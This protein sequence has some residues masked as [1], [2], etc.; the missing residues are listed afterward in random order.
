MQPLNA[1]WRID[2]AGNGND[3]RPGVDPALRQRILDEF[4]R[5]KGALD[6][7]AAN[8]TDQALDGLREAADS[9]MRALARVLL[10]AERQRGKPP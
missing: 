7:A 3:D 5:L 9:M 4:A 1:R 8:P 6:A 2:V 10:D